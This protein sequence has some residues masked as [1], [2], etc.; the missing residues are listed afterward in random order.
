MPGMVVGTPTGNKT[1]T[2]PWVGTP[3]GNRQ[4]Q[5][6]W[7]GTPGGNRLAFQRT[8]PWVPV[9]LS[10]SAAA[11]NQINLSWNNVG[12]GATYVLK[13]GSTTIYTGSG[14][15]KADTGLS[16]SKAYSYTIEAKSGSTVLSTDA[17]SASTPA[18][19]TTTKTVT[20]SAAS[21]GS[22]TGSNALRATSSRYSGYYSSSQGQQKS[23]FHFAIPAE[24]RNCVAIT[25][26]EFSCRNSHSYNNSGVTQYLAITHTS[27]AGSTFPGSTGLFGGR[28]S[29]KGG[30]YGNA[31]WVN[32]TNDREPTFNDTVAGNFRSRGAWG[33]VLA[34]PS[35]SQAYYSYWQAGARLRITYR[36]YT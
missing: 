36:V 34:A 26:V 6:V 5:E 18:R 21:S 13:R 2:D 14:L 9:D 1:V 32:I 35:S 3:A 30:W 23:S 33:I 22:Y 11:W 8:A 31:E 16:A 4:V 28:F 25:K 29:N 19:P 27:S 7:V 15:S 17:A 24:V 12:E 10:A 20:L